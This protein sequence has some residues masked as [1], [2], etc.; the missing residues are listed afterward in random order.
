MPGYRRVKCPGGGFKTAPGAAAAAR[1][2]A[3]Q[4]TR[5]ATQR[6]KAA[7]NPESKE[8]CHGRNDS[9]SLDGAQPDPFTQ[10]HDPAPV[11]VDPSAVVAF[12]AEGWIP[13]SPV[14]KRSGQ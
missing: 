7:L 10:P 9:Q 14:P 2:P 3:S 1:L 12:I 11:Y 4:R 6:A 8:P 13:V 5:A